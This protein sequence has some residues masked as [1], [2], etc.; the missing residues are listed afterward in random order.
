ML[1]IVDGGGECIQCARR[2]DRNDSGCENRAVI[3]SF[4]WDEVNHHSRGDAFARDR[5]APRPL[6]C[7]RSRQF[8]G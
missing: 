6:N 5:L 8:A 3:D 2:V 4:V 7:V 1:G